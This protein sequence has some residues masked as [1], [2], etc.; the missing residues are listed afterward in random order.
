MN[1]Q[2]LNWET[3]RN[4]SDEDLKYLFIL[5]DIINNEYKNRFLNKYNISDLKVGDVLKIQSNI[6][7]NSTLI[8][9]IL[10]IENSNISYKRISYTNSGITNADDEYK[11]N[12]TT[13]IS[14]FKDSKTVT[15]LDN[16]DFDNLYNEI[17]SARNLYFHYNKLKLFNISL[18]TFLDICCLLLSPV[19]CLSLSH[20][21]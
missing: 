18:F 9:K 7:S 12:F 13:L 4:L 19:W 3:I 16:F 14:V 6:Y 11:S 5:Q 1:V 10:K 2:E 17:T 21:F 8:I 20:F 15:R